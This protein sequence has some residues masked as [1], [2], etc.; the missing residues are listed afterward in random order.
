MFISDGG[1]SFEIKKKKVNHAPK[2]AGFC[3]PCL[4]KQNAKDF[5]ENQLK[6]RIDNTVANSDGN[7]F[8]STM[9]E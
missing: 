4:R 7:C 3:K 5:I 2:Q 1:I 9:K 6:L 8:L